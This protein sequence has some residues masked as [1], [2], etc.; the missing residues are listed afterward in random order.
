LLYTM[1]L[2]QGSNPPATATTTPS[3]SINNSPSSIFD[4]FSFVRGGSNH[5]NAPSSSLVQEAGKGPSTRPPRQQ[6]KDVPKQERQD[7]KREKITGTS[8]RF[9]AYKPTMIPVSETREQKLDT[10]RKQKEKRKIRYKE[11]RERRRP[12][13]NLKV[14]TPWGFWGQPNVSTYQIRSKTYLKSKLKVP[15]K[16]VVFETVMVDAFIGEVPV[17]HVASKPFSW[18]QKN[19]PRTGFTFVHSILIYSIGCSLVSYHH[20]KDKSQLPRLLQKFIDSDDEYRNNRFKMIPRIIEGPWLLKRS[21]QSAPVIVGKKL[22]MTYY[23]GRDYLECDMLCDSNSMASWIIAIARS[24]TGSII[25]EL[26]WTVEGQVK[27]ELP[28]QVFAGIRVGAV[29]FDHFTKVIFDEKK[30]PVGVIGEK[31]SESETELDEKIDDWW[32]DQETTEESKRSS[33]I[34]K[35]HVKVRAKDSSNCLFID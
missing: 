2:F 6:G 11:P 32:G 27:E 4:I 1:W 12:G 10:T 22:T 28:E 19:R 23:R 34:S 17:L 9:E 16:P 29:K 3:S 25:V 26:V 24:L 13:W 33:R 30:N 21:V 5:G 31:P 14:E 7:E 18:F 20:C 8:I 15:S 35:E